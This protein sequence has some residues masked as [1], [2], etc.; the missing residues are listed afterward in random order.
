MTC[1]KVLYCS[2]LSRE[3]TDL[4]YIMQPLFQRNYN[5]ENYD[6]LILI[7]NTFCKRIGMT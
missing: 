4:G 7:P 1:Y 5:A 2:K 3:Y 6:D